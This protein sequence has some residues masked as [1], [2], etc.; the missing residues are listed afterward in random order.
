MS[1]ARRPA[2]RTMFAAASLAALAAFAAPR[3]LAQEGG[4]APPDADEIRKKVIEIERLMKGAEEALAKST[5]TRAAAEK[6]AE[7]AEKLLDEKAQKETGKSAEQLRDETRS[8]SKEAKEALERLTKAAQEEARRAAEAMTALGGQRAEQAGEG[9]KKLLEKVKGE[10]E[11]AASGIQWLLDNAVQHGGGG[12]GQKPPPKQGDD[13]KD[14]KPEGQEE[15]KDTARTP[16]PES[17]RE[18]PRI[19]EDQQWYAELPA[20]VKKAYDTQDW[21]SI[22]PRWRELLREWTK[23]M[24]EE[25]ET[26]RR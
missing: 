24:A 12:G 14:K 3:A 15:P 26:E 19:P 21:D 2:V 7:A 5:N 17:P 23:K 25:L 22:P 13:P 1:T 10:G 18:K 16:P 4:D 8:G 11:G 9:V 20:Q 6:A